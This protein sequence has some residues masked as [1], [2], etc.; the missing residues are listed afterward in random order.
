MFDDDFRPKN[1]LFG[2]RC[3]T[4]ADIKWKLG[5]AIGLFDFIIAKSTI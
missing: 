1:C 4:N 2:L 3:Q 5:V